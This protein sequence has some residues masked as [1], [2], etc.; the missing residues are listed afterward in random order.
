MA[1]LDYLKPLTEK[2]EN[3]SNTLNDLHDKLKTVTLFVYLK[4][5]LQCYI[6]IALGIF[7]IVLLGIYHYL[8]R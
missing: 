3:N 2:L 4:T 1:I 6:N 8:L 7:P 5:K